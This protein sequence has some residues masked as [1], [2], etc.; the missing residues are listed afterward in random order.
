MCSVDATARYEGMRQYKYNITCDDDGSKVGW[1]EVGR[2]TL[3]HRRRFSAS[4]VIS[5]EV[6]TGHVVS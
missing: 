3:H 1:E 5:V 2:E 6:Q 4:C